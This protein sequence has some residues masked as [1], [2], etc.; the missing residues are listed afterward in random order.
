MISSYKSKSTNYIGEGYLV[1]NLNLEQG[2]KYKGLISHENSKTTN[3]YIYSYTTKLLRGMYI[4][5]NLYTVSENALKV[6]SLDTLD[7]ISEL[8]IK[9]E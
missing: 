2:F 5:N 1:Y 4:D 3:K 6:N 7:L 8:K 9:G